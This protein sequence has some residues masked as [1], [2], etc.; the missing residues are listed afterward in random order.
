MVVRALL[1]VLV[2]APAS[3]FGQ[4]DFRVYI[5]H[6]RLFLNGDRLRRLERD[7]ERETPRWLRLVELLH[8]GAPVGDRP[9]AEAL[10]WRLVHDEQAGR[11]AVAW[12]VRAA[13]EGFPTEGDLR[14]G[15]LVFDWTQD[16]ADE[17][18]KKTIIDG[19]VLGAEG[20]TS[21]AGSDIGRIRDGV[22]AAVALAGHWD[23]SEPTLGKLLDNQW[24]REILPLLEGGQLT[25]N[26]EELVAVL[27]ICHVIRSNLERDL[28]QEAPEVFRTLPL[29]RILSYLPQTELSDEGRLRKRVTSDGSV[30][31]LA[32]GRIAEMLLVDY[33]IGLRDFQFLQGWLRNDSFTL[34]GPMG[35]FYEF[36]WIN[37]YVPGLSPTSG[38]V[39][40]YDPVRGRVFARESW[41][42]GALWLGWFGGK[43]IAREGGS[44]KQVEAGKEPVVFSLPDAAIVLG[45]SSGKVELTITKGRQPFG[46]YIWT[47]GMAEGMQ[48]P[49]KIGKSD[50]QMYQAAHGGVIELRNDPQ[51]KRPSIEYDEKI[52]LQFREGTPAPKG[53][54]PTL[55]PKL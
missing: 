13:S 53:T 39:A 31:D 17:S 4:A 6:P 32:F 9:A 48:Y 51:A 54:A 52:R 46:P 23:G 49:I 38:P 34:T 43:L 29:A 22:L 30:R 50:F 27:E 15:A 28:W 35:A 11:E 24:K 55:G 19:L 42:D 2:V 44:E 40:A 25:D 47:V 20:A 7:A 1:F 21:I 41:E 37:P 36:L 5:D 8:A 14:E 18:Q 12:A 33:E 45:G 26:G 10:L 3:L 16:L